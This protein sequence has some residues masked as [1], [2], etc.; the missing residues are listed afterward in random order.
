MKTYPLR[1]L[2]VCCALLA[3]PAAAQV[4]GPPLGLEIDPLGA[5]YLKNL[6]GESVPFDAYQIVSAS[7][8]L[9]P[10]G[11]QS[12][13][14]QVALD[15]A[16]V[17][18]A[19][20]DGALA[21]G[22]ANPSAQNLAEL[23]LG[24]FGALDPGSRF[25]IGRPFAGLLS[26]SDD[27][28]FFFKL[29][30]DPSPLEGPLSFLRPPRG[31]LRL[32][33]NWDGSTWLW[34]TGAGPLS[35]DGYQIASESGGLDPLGWLSISD[36]VN[37][38]QISTV[39]GALGASSLTFGEANPGPS[40]LAELN[41][42]GVGTLQ[43]GAQFYL[44]RPFRSLDEVQRTSFF[45]S[46]PGTGSQTGAIELVQV[47]EP[48]ARALLAIG[49]FVAI[50]SSPWTLRCN[51]VVAGDAGRPQRTPGNRERSQI[52]ART[53]RPVHPLPLQHIQRIDIDDPLDALR[54]LEVGRGSRGGAPQ[55]VAVEG[56][57]LHVEAMQPPQPGDRR[58]RGP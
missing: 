41:L 38:G 10:A 6:T 27:V 49:L 14:D 57:R 1:L 21:F 20:G 45:Y 56:L 40:N 9:S 19:L 52:H 47:P 43:G 55:T 8:R 11:W 54:R 16:L 18:G 46:A 5:T 23:N 17:Q 48:G 50:A 24:G 4:A 51:G 58:R 35:F 22:E 3:G 31:D 25:G 7:G 42:G 13:A 29:A 12:I 39:L 53:A 32:L 15:P 28:Q 37:S 34:N 33:V 26:T 2:V 30:G 44:G 36:Y